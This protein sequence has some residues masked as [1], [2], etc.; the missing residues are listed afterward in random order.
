MTK[1]PLLHGT[2][3]VVDSQPSDYSNLL[4]LADGQLV[5]VHFFTTGDAALR[6]AAGGWQPDRRAA[7]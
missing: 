7:A 5:T 1:Q 4:P 2:V 6:G 3:V